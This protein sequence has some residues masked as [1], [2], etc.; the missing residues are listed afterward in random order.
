ML[1]PPQ[2]LAVKSLSNKASLQQ[3]PMK[4]SIRFS[5]DAAT[6]SA[7]APTYTANQVPDDIFVKG[8]EALLASPAP[9]SRLDRL[10]ALTLLA[11]G[12]IERF[13]EELSQWRKVNPGKY[14]DLKG[15]DIASLFEGVTGFDGEESDV[16]IDFR[17]VDLTK[18]N[19]RGM[20]VLQA[21]FTAQEEEDPKDQLMDAILEGAKFS[22]T[23]LKIVT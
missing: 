4:H 11:N 9:V 17:S 5:G 1:P 20:K 16:V 6:P 15:A 3:P 12:Q 7:G 18:A 10:M 21:M 19:F 14:F 8:P 13:N 23:T 2:S 22:N